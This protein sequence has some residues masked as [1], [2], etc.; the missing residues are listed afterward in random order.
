MLKIGNMGSS[1]KLRRLGLKQLVIIGITLGVC[2]PRVITV[3]VS[4]YQ[5]RR[6]LLQNAYADF[7]RSTELAA[8]AS[9]AGVW[10]LDKAETEK[11]MSAIFRDER[12]VSIRIVDEDGK[13]FFEKS[14]AARD[15]GETLSNRRDIENKGEKIGNVEVRFSF[16]E[17]SAAIRRLLVSE[18]ISALLEL[19]LCLTMLLIFINRRVVNRLVLISDQAKMIANNKL[20]QTFAWEPTD[21]IG[22]LGNAL[23]S[24][25]TS[26]K[27]LFQ[28]ITDKNDQLRAI[29]ENLES[30]VTERTATIRM[31]LDN[32][33]TGFLVMTRDFIIQPGCSKSCGPLLKQEPI[34]GSPLPVVLQMSERDASTFRVMA[35]Q[36]FEDILPEDVSLA[37]IPSLFK[38]G[39]RSL[40]VLGSA[41]RDSSNT[42]QA[43]LFTISDM[44]ELIESQRE[45]SLKSSLLRILQH[46]DSFR[47]FVVDTRS[48]IRSALNAQSKSDQGLVKR[49]V[50]TIKGNVATFDLSEMTEFIH[51]IENSQVITESQINSIED[52]LVVFLKSH[53]S[54]LGIDYQA[55]EILKVAVPKTELDFIANYLE[56]DETLGHKIAFLSSWINRIRLVP[57]SSVFQSMDPYVRSVAERREKR[58]QLLVEEDG[59]L[60]NLSQ[61]QE[62]KASVVHLVRNS[63]D[64]GIEL[65]S[66]RHNKNPTG[67]IRVEFHELPSEVVVEISDDG[68]GIDRDKVRL[69]AIESGLLKPEQKPSPDEIDRLIFED[70]LSTAE[71]VTD[72]SGRGIGMSAVRQSV[73]NLGGQVDIVSHQGKGTLFRFTFPKEAIGYKMNFTTYAKSA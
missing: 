16:Y 35:D 25:R 69:K 7:N 21:E 38:I 36:V 61:I 22:D 43:L 33:K 50:H 30:L 32:V 18:A 17:T 1:N 13:V 23:E 28:E 72:I 66:L 68:A 57:F 11:T 41:V 60:V 34:A 71:T 10:N 39:T 47:E 58:V 2:V 59:P 12:L 73:Q 19:A 6:K 20:D 52:R 67:T 45:N 56:Q 70:G 24:T 15:K 63:I 8:L 53:E 49:E 62:F 4:V 40:S 65:P 48:R 26:L 42:V 9:V 27:K 29:N 5:D 3:G 54:I 44:T 37:Q 51:Q 64:H 46:M 14:D 31:I 55:T